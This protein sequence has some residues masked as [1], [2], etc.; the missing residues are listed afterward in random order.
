MTISQPLPP[1]FTTLSKLMSE[2]QRNFLDKILYVHTIHL[3][4]Y[5]V[6]L[7]EANHD[8]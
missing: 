5:S 1:L 3:S 4:F 6:L 7:G 2:L 8:Y